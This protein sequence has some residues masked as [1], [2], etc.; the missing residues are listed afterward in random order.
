M[1][2][3]SGSS[4]EDV[5]QQVSH[6]WS[7]LDDLCQDDPEAYRKFID[8][9]MK[10]GAEFSSPP[11][12]HSSICTNILEPN[13]RLLYINL[14][15]WKRVPAPQHPGKPLPL[16]AGKLETEDKGGQ[17]PYV[18]LD[19]AVNP[20]L[21][22]DCK[23][24]ENEMK[25]LYILLLNFAQKQH[26][27]KLSQQYTLVSESPRSTTE[28]LYRR[29]GF[30]QWPHLACKADSKGEIACQT[31]ASLLQ[32]MS[33]KHTEKEEE[34][35]VSHEPT[36]HKKKN[37]I[38]VIS[39]TFVQPQ[40]PKYQLEVRPGAAGAPRHVELTV[41]LPKVSYMSECQLQIS[42]DDVLLEVEDVYHLLLDF[43][44]LVDEDSATAVFNKKRRQLTLRVNIL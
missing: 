13:Q 21:L 12:L 25:Q 29:L 5:L 26:N 28:D 44:N 1:L 3:S 42:K 41:E 15:S 34:I 40:R 43:P 30:Q 32:K 6:F 33:S 35:F 37:L 20:G 38:Q 7:M 11:E 23:P 36:E 39:S 16:C 9:Q 18:V 10:E 8:K 22:Q 14:C 17:G 19:V 31:P 24:N 27:L 4:K 2:S